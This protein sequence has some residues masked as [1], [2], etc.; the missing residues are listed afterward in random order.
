MKT[1][2]LPPVWAD[3]SGGENVNPWSCDG[4]IGECG[5][6]T[7]LDRLEHQICREDGGHLPRSVAWQAFLGL[8]GQGREAWRTF[9][10]VVWHARLDGPFGNS[11]T[12]TR[13]LAG[14]F[15]ATGT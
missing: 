6:I 9:L 15:N 13:G 5:A 4:P 14:L 1:R 8:V 10:R 2:S 12:W 11:G 7:G 3:T